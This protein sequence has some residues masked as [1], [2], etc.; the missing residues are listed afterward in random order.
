M[1]IETTTE[2]ITIWNKTKEIAV[3]VGELGT[4]LYLSFSADQTKYTAKISVEDEH[5]SDLLHVKVSKK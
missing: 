4:D 2:G 5:T 1:T 3:I